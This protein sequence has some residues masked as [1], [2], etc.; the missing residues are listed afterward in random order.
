M[1]LEIERKYLVISDLYKK[2]A[3]SDSH[4]I[5]AY[6]ART[7]H[8]VV[9]VRVRDE[10]AYIT[11]KSRITGPTRSEWE[12]EIPLSDAQEMIAKISDG[13]L[14]DKTRYIVEYDGLTWEIDE[15]HGALEGLV[16]AEV[17][18]QDEHVKPEL[19]PFVG[20]DVTGERRFYNSALLEIKALNELKIKQ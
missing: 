7:D 2:M 1:A 10:K 20:R 15:F 11:V 17:E 19:P 13:K 14:I 16:V 6:L 9:R 3:M 5:Q 18:L 8:G 4:I 12:Y